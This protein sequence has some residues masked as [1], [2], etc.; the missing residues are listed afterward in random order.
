[1]C[2]YVNRKQENRFKPKNKSI[3]IYYNIF[4]IYYTLVLYKY[5]EC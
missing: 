4:I 2:K 3:K 5:I 1:M